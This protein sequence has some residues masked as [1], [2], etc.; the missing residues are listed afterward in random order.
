MRGSCAMGREFCAA[1]ALAMRLERDS[2]GDNGAQAPSYTD[3]GRRCHRPRRRGSRVRYVRSGK[4]RP[5]GAAAA[6]MSP[7]AKSAHVAA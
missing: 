1:A 6:M 2:R 3:A 5:T 7:H 4:C